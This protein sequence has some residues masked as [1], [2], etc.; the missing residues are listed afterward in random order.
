MNIHGLSIKD[1]KDIPFDHE[2]TKKHLHI[3]N[4]IEDGILTISMNETTHDV[5]SV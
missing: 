3:E 1:R 4:L 5:L 2:I